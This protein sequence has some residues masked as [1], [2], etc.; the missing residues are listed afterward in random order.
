M[1]TE[2]TKSK[3]VGDT[4]AKMLYPIAKHVAKGC[5]GCGKRADALN[6]AIPYA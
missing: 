2:G 4:V 3:G 6:K 1:R 5:G